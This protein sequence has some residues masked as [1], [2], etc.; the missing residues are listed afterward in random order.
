MWMLKLRIQ[1][2]EK[3]IVVQTLIL[4]MASIFCW[5]AGINHLEMVLVTIGLVYIFR[6]AGFSYF[7]VFSFIL[8][9]SFLQEYFASIS[10]A[11]AAGRLAWDTS[12]PIYHTELFVCTMFF[13]LQNYIYSLL[14]KY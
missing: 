4:L 3:Y 8:W 14:Q 10:P 12:V 1:K 5:I 13:L 9:F 11:L 2:R 7:T 6:V